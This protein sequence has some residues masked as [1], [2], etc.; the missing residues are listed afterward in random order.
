[1]KILCPIHKDELELIEDSDFSTSA[2]AEPFTLDFGID[3]LCDCGD[4]WSG[5]AFM[6]DGSG[7]RW[8]H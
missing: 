2:D 7:N 6:D 5:N 1:M 8:L 4:E 3:W